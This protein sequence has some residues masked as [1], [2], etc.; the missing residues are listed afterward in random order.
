MVKVA[1][2][3]IS[4]TIISSELDCLKELCRQLRQSSD[5]SSDTVCLNCGTSQ[6]DEQ[7]RRCYCSDYLVSE[8]EVQ[9]FLYLQESCDLVAQPV[10]QE[11][12]QLNQVHYY[13]SDDNGCFG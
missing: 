8:E 7:C 3:D 1:N 5:N 9:Q 11:L 13:G 6:P 4:K 2:V 12:A 10:Y